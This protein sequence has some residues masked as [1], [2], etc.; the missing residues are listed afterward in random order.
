MTLT[1]HLRELVHWKKARFR[2]KNL[3][4][5]LSRSAHFE[6]KLANGVEFAWQ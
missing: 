2:V 6:I 1:R 5:L 4:K 3:A